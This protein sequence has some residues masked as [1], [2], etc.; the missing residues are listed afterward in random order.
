MRMTI[1]INISIEVLSNSM[2]LRILFAVLQ[3]A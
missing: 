1:K 3:L 2:A